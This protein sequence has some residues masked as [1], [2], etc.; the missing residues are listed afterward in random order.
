MRLSKLFTET[1]FDVS[2]KEVSIN[3]QLLEKAGYISKVMSG[4]YTYLPLGLKVLNNIES[5]VRNEMNKIGGQ[6]ILMPAL[7]PKENWIK[8]GRW[9]KVDI[10]YKITE[11]NKEICLGPTHEE[12]VTPLAG[13]YINSYKDL[14][15]AI[16]QI[17]TKFRNE[18]RAKSG[19]LRCREFRMKD[20]Y[21][22]HK[23]Q[24]DLNNF[25]EIVSQSYL[26]IFKECGLEN[27]TYKTY[28]SGGIFSKFSHE[29]QAITDYGEDIIYVCIKCKSAINKEIINE[30][31]KC[32]ECDTSDLIEKKS[33]EIGN[34]F[35][36]N[37]KFS[38]P[39]E[40][41]YIDI[42]NKKEIVYMGCYGIGTSRL[43]GAIVE[44]LHDKDGIVFPLKVAPY[45]IIIIPIGKEDEIKNIG[46]NLYKEIDK[47][48]IDVLY[49]D[50]YDL[51]PGKKFSDADLIGIPFKIII[52][53]KNIE[54]NSF[55][56]KSRDNKIVK[57]L[58]LEELK[59]YININVKNN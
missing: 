30:Y 17:Q 43:I 52:S 24:E 20:L 28:A 40:L 59:N 58:S 37:T 15:T 21:S 19:L 12:I 39:F 27:I 8:T 2:N 32:P 57:Y 13:I 38:E 10:L 1:K 35:K 45:K 54:N 18:P 14:P 47:N 16:Y 42:S 29:F 44:A 6:E 50:R 7:Q 53:K 55:E 11:S 49:D 9:D 25:Y 4:V 41:N 36:L 5:I 48:I 33:I 22:F 23:D 56:L 26:N 46:E 34:I 51:S 3:A 31:K